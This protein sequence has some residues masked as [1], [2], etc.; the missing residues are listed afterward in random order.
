MYRRGNQGGEGLWVLRHPRRCS[1][2][3]TAA[4]HLSASRPIARQAWP[5][6]LGPHS[7]PGPQ[8][9]KITPF[10]TT[11]IHVCGQEWVSPSLTQFCCWS[12]ALAQTPRFMNTV[13]PTR[14][15]RDRA[16]R[17]PPGSPQPL[18]RV[19]TLLERLPGLSETRRTRTG[20]LQRLQLGD[21]HIEG[22]QRPAGW[23]AGWQEP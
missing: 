19:V 14:G 7:E 23:T 21:S 12:P 15:P 16:H 5:S 10:P 17:Q 13:N 2:D 11:A 3:T 18:P 4:G 9:P 1:G 20:S 8:G 6:L 22:P